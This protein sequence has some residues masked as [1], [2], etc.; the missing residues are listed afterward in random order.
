MSK[1]LRPLSWLALL[2]TF[3]APVLYATDQ[4]GESSLRNL[5][6]IGM[7]VWF[8]VAVVRDQLRQE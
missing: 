1:F 3:L 4:I 8:S 2:A 6:I 5:L 7:F